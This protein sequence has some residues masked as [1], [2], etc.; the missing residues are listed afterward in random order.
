MHTLR[1]LAVSLAAA[2]TLLIHANPV[3]AQAKYPAKTVEVVV[4]YAPG[5]GTDNLMRMIT[6][7]MDENKWSPVPV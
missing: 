6:G 4:P 5:G 7:I 1:L 3:L 2:A